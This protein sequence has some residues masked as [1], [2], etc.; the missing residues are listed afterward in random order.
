MNESEPQR[1]IYFAWLYTNW[2]GAQIFLLAIM[3]IARPQWDIRVILPRASSPDFLRF[4]DDLGVPY[5]FVEASLDQ[6]PARG[7]IEKLMRQKRRVTAEREIL[8]RLNRYDLKRNILHIE[9]APWQS[10]QLL[11]ILS[12]RGANVFLTLHNFLSRASFF[13][14]TLWKARLQFVSRLRGIHFIASNLDTKERLRG[15]VSDKFWQDVTVAHTCVD[16][17][18]ISAAAASDFEKREI[19]ARH[20]IPQDKFVVLCVG[21]FVDRKGRWVFLEAAK[22][23]AAKNDQYV[24]IW[25]SP[26]DADA[27]DRSRIDSYGLGDRFRIVRSSTVGESRIDVLKFFNVANVFALP[28]FV[29]GLPIA[30]LEAMA[31]GIPAVSTNVFAIPEAVKHLETGLLVEA[32]DSKALASAIEQIR[33]DRDMA[34]KLSGAGREFVLANFDERDAARKC[35]AAYERCFE[36]GK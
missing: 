36:R 23:L 9:A 17:V 35:L 8:R 2:G 30:L 13:R 20:S 7:L 14:E 31:L 33:S 6:S 21:Q 24:F 18:Q 22:E 28:S 26:A 1:T 4:L 10:W 16:P 19:R 5:E 15:W 32:G 3:K 11:L 12:L 27:A 29:E 25:L 34:E